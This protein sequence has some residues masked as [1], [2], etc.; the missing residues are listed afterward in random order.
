[1]IH[2]LIFRWYLH[3]KVVKE[4]VSSVFPMPSNMDIPQVKQYGNICPIISPLSMHIWTEYTTV[5]THGNIFPTY[6]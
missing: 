6:T 3:Y 5:L 2:V 1:M 4:M